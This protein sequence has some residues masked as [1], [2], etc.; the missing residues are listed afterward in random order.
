MRFLTAA[1][2]IFPALLHAAVLPPDVTLTPGAVNRVRI[3][4]VAIYGDTASRALPRL[5][6]LTHARREIVTAAEDAISRG[7]GVIAPAAEREQIENPL[8]FWGGF[9]KA[10][11]H[12]TTTRSRAHTFPRGRSGSFAA[13]AAGMS[14]RTVPCASM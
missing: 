9:E 2:A 12:D 11:F 10:R 13:S 7:A 6:L 4:S 1:L 5:V 8:A 14:S 3:G